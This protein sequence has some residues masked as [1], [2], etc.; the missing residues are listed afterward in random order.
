[1]TPQDNSFQVNTLLKN[2]VIL[3][4]FVVLMVIT[5]LLS[6][7]GDEDTGD[8]R[9]LQYS[10]ALTPMQDGST[11][12]V[13][14]QKWQ[15]TSGHI[16]WVTVGVPNRD[17]D[18]VGS[19][20]AALHASPHNNADASMVRLDLDRDYQ[21]GETFEIQ[22]AINQRQLYTHTDNGYTI[23]F[24][25]GWYDRAAVDSLEVRVN[26]PCY[27]SEVSAQ[28][29]P[30]YLAGDGMDWSGISLSKG[31]KY[32]VSFSFPNRY[33]PNVVV[34]GNWNALKR[35]GFPPFL[36]FPLWLLFV[37][38]AKRW[39]RGGA[40]SGGGIYYGG[41]SGGS[42]YVSSCAC[43]CA[44]CACACA[45]AGGG[46]AGCSRKNEHICPVC[47]ERD[48]ADNMTTIISERDLHEHIKPLLQD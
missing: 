37:I 2:I 14:Y 9:I 38:L 5:V 11:K 32:P 43:A 1:M 17:Y 47:K 8:Y 39:D 25:P 48:K 4:L 41:S 16:P 15:V 40:Y 21:Q 34:A 42:C 46:G 28:P 33:A 23:S 12:I 26:L 18:V 45:C 36:I 31:E 7:G 24:T 3:T 44:G 35:N 27:T 20:L 29:A 13:Y 22:F 30:D 10:V 6:I 19:G